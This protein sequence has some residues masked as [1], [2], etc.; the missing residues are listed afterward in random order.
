MHMCA[1]PAGLP[2]LN[3]ALRYTELQ[4]FFAGFNVFNILFLRKNVV[5]KNAAPNNRTGWTPLFA[6]WVLVTVATLGSLFFSEVMG[7]G[8]CCDTWQPF[9]QRGDGGSGLYAVLVSAYR[10]VPLGT[11]SGHRSFAIR[12]KSTAL[13]DCFGESGLAD[14]YVPGTFGCRHHSEKRPTLCTGYSLFGNPH[15]LTRFFEHSLTLITHFYTDR[16]I[17]VLYA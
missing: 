7:P 13:R 14:R 16:R 5:S 1:M 11:D 17:V 4:V 6:A 2:L 3:N 15:F 10:H 12:P 9:F 8:Y